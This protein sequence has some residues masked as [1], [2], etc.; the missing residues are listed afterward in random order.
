MNLEKV[1]RGEVLSIFEKVSPPKFMRVHVGKINWDDN[2]TKLSEWTRR[3]LRYHA[4]DIE[5]YDVGEADVNLAYSLY[6]AALMSSDYAYIIDRYNLDSIMKTGQMKVMSEYA[7]KKGDDLDTGWRMLVDLHRL[8]D[9]REPPEAKEFVQDI[10]SW[11]SDKKTHTWNGDEEEWYRRYRTSC[12]RVIR[13]SG[14][15]PDVKWDVD[16]FLMN[17]D[18]WSTNGSGFEPEYGKVYVENESKG[19]TMPVHKNKWAVMWNTSKYKLKKLMFKKRKQVCK[20]VMKSEPGKVRAVISSDLSLYLKMAYLSTVIDSMFRRRTDTTLYMNKDERN[21][22]WQKMAKNGHWRMPLDQS[23][24]DRNATMR[25]VKITIE[26]IRDFV[27]DAY[28]DATVRELFDLVLYAIDGGYVIIDDEK[29]LIENGLLS[30]WRWTAMLGTMINLTELDLACEWVSSNSNESVLLND[31]NAQGD[32]DWMDL[33]RYKDGVMLWLAYSSFNLSVNP[34]KFFLSR[35]RDEYLRRVMDGDKVTGYPARSIASLLFRNPLSERESVGAERIRQSFNKWKLF[36]ERLDATIDHSFFRDNMITDCVQSVYGLSRRVVRNML[37]CDVLS[38]GIGYNG[39]LVGHYDIIADKSGTN[40]RISVNALEGFKEWASYVAKFGVDAATAEAFCVSTLDTTNTRLLPSWV[41]YI[42]TDDIATYPVESGTDWTRRGSVA[43]GS[44]TKHR[45]WHKNIRWYKSYKDLV[46]VNEYGT[47]EIASVYSKKKDKEL[48]LNKYLVH[49][50]SLEPKKGLSFTSASMSAE[51]EK[52]W[53]NFDA[54]RDKLEHKPKRW[55]DDFLK[56]R[57][58]SNVSPRVGW[59]TDIV[60]YYGSVLLRA[61]INYYLNLRRPSY[62]L[63]ERLLGNIDL[64]VPEML[65]TCT[66]RVVE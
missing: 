48:R 59:G 54:I 51:P 9:F 64:A 23:E 40:D 11:V 4:Y 30:G 65:D 55:R 24:F 31:F 6:R 35:T 19:R 16:S 37:L 36:A 18:V 21:N 43:I 49:G 3:R 56:G 10:K 5:I 15:T 50:F 8:N 38:G 66:I 27:L 1:A 28:D 29:I 61:A 2:Y 52:A 45:A 20:A 34:G 12:R 33:M 46:S 44:S 41:K 25:Q 7:K 26:E 57:L 32:D 17:G 42:I 22:L 58:K 13:R 60:G 62:G 63:W 53:E 14:V 39:G 47:W